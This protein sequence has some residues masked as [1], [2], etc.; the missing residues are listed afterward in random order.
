L[1]SRTTRSRR[2]TAWPPLS[3]HWHAR[4]NRPRRQGRIPPTVALYVA[5]KNQ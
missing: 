5:P 4:S 3:R 2:E 1:R